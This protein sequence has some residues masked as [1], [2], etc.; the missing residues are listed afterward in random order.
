[1]RIP[2]RLQPSSGLAGIYGQGG[3]QK[4]DKIHFVFHL[5]HRQLP[6]E[7]C[8]RP[9]KHPWGGSEL[10]HGFLTVVED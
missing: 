4:E 7:R 2:A 9:W 8:E 6:T 10:L 1:M 5:R 3:E